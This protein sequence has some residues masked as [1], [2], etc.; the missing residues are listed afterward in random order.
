MEQGMTWMSGRRF[1]FWAATRG[2]PRGARRRC[3]GSL[4][5]ALAKVIKGWDEGVAQM[6]VGERAYLICSPDYAYGALLAWLRCWPGCFGWTAAA[7]VLLAS[8]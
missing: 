5:L 8:P 1:R 2:Q 7:S 4:L 6:S 3:A